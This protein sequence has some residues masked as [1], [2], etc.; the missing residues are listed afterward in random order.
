[1]SLAAGQLNRLIEIQAKGTAV[2]GTNQPVPVWTMHAR[3]WAQGMGAT[4]MAAVRSAHET[5]TL[6]PVKYS[7]R[8]RYC[9]DAG[10]TIGMRVLYKGV[11]FDIKD[12]RHDF[13]G[14]EYTDLV[15]ETGATNG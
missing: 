5:A 1:M 12:I 6:P 9:P 15:C 4:G 3:R 8:L 2:D 11:V 13:A 7:W 10:I 14:H